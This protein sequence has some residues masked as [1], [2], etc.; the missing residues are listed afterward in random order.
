MKKLSELSIEEL[1]LAIWFI[2][3]TFYTTTDEREAAYRRMDMLFLELRKR[4]EQLGEID[5]YF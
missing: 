4:R 5:F 2:D 3:K 1:L